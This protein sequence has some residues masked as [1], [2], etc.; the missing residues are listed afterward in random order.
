MSA[1]YGG[2]MVTLVVA[3]SISATDGFLKEREVQYIP[4]SRPINPVVE[5]RDNKPSAK[6]FLPLEWD[7]NEDELNGP[8]SKRGWTMQEGLLPN[9]LL[10]YTSSQMI[11]KC[12]EEQRFERGVTKNLQDEV[13]ETLRYNDDISFGSGFSL[14]TEHIRAI[15]EVSRLPAKQSKLHVHTKARDVS[16]LVPSYRRLHSERTF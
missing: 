12:R 14:E 1:I 15:Q 7:K 8:W 11:W 10:H 6:V 13:A 5:S 4:V 3:S 9:R 16:S 2:S